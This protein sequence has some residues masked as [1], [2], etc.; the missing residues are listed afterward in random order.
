MNKNK[1]LH[2]CPNCDSELVQPTQW[3]RAN[4]RFSWRVWTRCPNCE[5][6]AVGV[7]GEKEIDAFEQVLDVGANALSNTLNRVE[8]GNMAAMADSFTAALESDLIGPD[9]FRV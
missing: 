5:H 4:E 8:K 6:E 1:G 2:I 9:D 3:E 7:Y